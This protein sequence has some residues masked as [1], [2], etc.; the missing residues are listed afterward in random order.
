[1]PRF[2]EKE[3][4]LIRYLA[5]CYAEDRQSPGCDKLMKDL[6]FHERDLRPLLETMRDWKI[7]QNLVWDV[8]GH[9]IFV[10]TSHAVH[11][12]REIE[13]QAAVQPD[14]VE[15]AET[16]MRRHRWPARLVIALIVLWY[17]FSLANLVVDFFAKILD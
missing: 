13:A 2:D 7:V 3:K 16:W 10:I 8:N 1:M 17:G 9:A 14:H 6:N 12:A 4:A 15:K 5:N 11:Y